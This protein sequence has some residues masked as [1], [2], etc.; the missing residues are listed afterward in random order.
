MKKGNYLVQ[1]L[2]I[3][4]GIILLLIGFVL[5]FI[6]GPGLLLIFGGLVIL[7]GH[8]LWAKRL[9]NKTKHESSIIIKSSRKFIKQVNF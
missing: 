7:A 9:L 4:L 1:F 3:T 5:L 8:F 6:P 2:L